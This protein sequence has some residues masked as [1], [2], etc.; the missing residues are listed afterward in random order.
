MMFSHTVQNIHFGNSLPSPIS[1]PGAGG[2]L[3]DSVRLGWMLVFS[4][5]SAA[6][7]QTGIDQTVTPRLSLQVTLS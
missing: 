2:T 5:G 7:C 3:E 1:G 6:V 4:S